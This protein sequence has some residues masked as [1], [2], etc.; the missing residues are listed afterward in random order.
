MNKVVVG[1]GSNL[2]DRLNFINAAKKHLK[3]LL[4]TPEALFL[5]APLYETPPLDCPPGSHHFLN[6]VVAFE[7]SGT[8][9]ELLTQTQL[10]EESL[11]RP[12]E[13][14]FNTPRTV[15]LDI[16]IFGERVIHSDSLEIPHPRAH[17]REFVLK[18][19]ADLFPELKLPGQTS[20]VTELL[21]RLDSTNLIPT[22]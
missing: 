20:T 19:L 4:E 6:T 17:L 5:E 7:W 2:G 22:S 13:H 1:I 3:A 15:D 14:G 10:I 21:N 16:I 8:P 12:A 11:G 18:P 9:D